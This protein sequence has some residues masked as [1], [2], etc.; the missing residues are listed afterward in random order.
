VTVE[1]SRL[2]ADA[3]RELEGEDPSTTMDRAVQLGVQLVRGAHEASIIVARRG[4]RVETPAATDELVA[5]VEQL[6]QQLQEGPCLDAL[7]KQDVVRSRDISRDERWPTWGPKVA[8]ETPIRSMLCFR[9][10]TDDDDVV[11]GLNL[12]S[13]NPDAFDDE[14]VED[15]SLLAAQASVAIASA[16]EIAQLRTAVD[17]RTL[18]GQAQGILMER[19][20]LGPAQAFAVLARVSQARNVKVSQVAADLVETRLLPE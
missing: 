8:A 19:F 7:R 5:R 18:I 15:G 11:G 14:D 20:G 10:L 2:V 17:G 6:Q 12:Y 9:P 13:Y 16:Q 1:L 3:A 4:N